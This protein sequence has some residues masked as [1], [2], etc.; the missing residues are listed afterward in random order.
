MQTFTKKFLV[1]GLIN[2]YFFVITILDL[3]HMEELYE[4]TY[5]IWSYFNSVGCCACGLPHCYRQFGSPEND[6]QYW[7]H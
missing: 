1:E 7:Y 5:E 6:R 4:K 2:Y 3:N